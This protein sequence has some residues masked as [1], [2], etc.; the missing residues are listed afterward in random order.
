[1]VVGALR[2]LV[3]LMAEALVLSF[4]IIVTRRNIEVEINAMRVCMSSFRD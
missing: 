1:M 2:K 4:L 3:T